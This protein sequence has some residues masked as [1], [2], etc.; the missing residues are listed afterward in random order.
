MDHAT[1]TPALRDWLAA[2]D[3]GFLAELLRLRPDAATPPPR[4]SEVLAA[5]LQLRASARRALPGLDATALAVLEAAVDLGADLE[6]VAGAAV[7]DS[8]RARLAAAG[9]PVRERPT[10]AQLRTALDAL[11]QRAL[12]IGDG[13]GRGGRFAGRAGLAGCALRVADGAWAA[14]PPGWALLPDPDRPTPERLR[15]ALA[16]IDDHQRRLLETL[17]EAGGLGTTREADPAADPAL[18]VPRLIAAGLLERVDHATVRLPAAV[19]ALLRGIPLPEG[20]VPLRPD[21][22]ATLPAGDADA[23]GAAAALE[24]IRGVR[25]LLELLGEAPAAVRRDGTVGVREHRRLVEALGP[26]LPRLV[27]VAAAAGL[28]G[29]GAPHPL[30]AEDTGGDYLAP[31]PAADAFLAAEPAARWAMLIDGLR[32]ADVDPAADRPLLSPEARRA[33]LPALRTAIG[34]L[35]LDA[36]AAVADP[37][38]AL[39]HRRPLVAVRTPPAALESALADLAA[40][41]LIAREG[42]AAAATA[43]WRAARAATGAE[44]AARL[45]PL[46][47]AP[48]GDLIAQ[49]DLT[50]LVPGPAEPALAAALARFTDVESTGVASVHRMSEESVRRGLDS[51]MTAA[52]LH[53]LLAERALGEVPQAMGFLIDD[54][55][56]RHGILRGGPAASYLR[57]A[58]AAEL[59]G[60][61][62]SPAAA[63]LGLRRLADT[64]LIAQAPLAE[65]LAA[66]RAAG[67]PAVAEDADGAVLSLAEEPRRVAEALPRTPAPQPPDAAAI[68]RAVDDVVRGDAAAAAGDGAGGTRIGMDD[69]PATGAAAQD[70]LAR[71]ARAGIEVTIGYVDRNGRALRRRVRPVTVGGGHVDALDPA[72]GRVLRFLM[73]RVTEVVQEAPPVP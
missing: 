57:C 32:G 59:A 56:R 18:P 63:G 3:R 14:L 52:E 7:L 50:I 69:D 51:G 11:R 9:A 25:D 41:G 29:V 38:G 42:P 73:H 28:L 61:M 12:V 6:P 17:V 4:S 72:E 60:I 30:P 58:D 1:E 31:A 64:V 8:V 54:V 53:A 23:R 39:L 67:R 55:A 24:L 65:V 22:P 45:A 43:A 15:A 20:R 36:G 62:A 37:A 70:L 35:L 27:A 47:P 5:R 21:P 19:R 49:E 71:A 48:T 66:L 10:L 2:R 34:D 40:L 68:A 46:L 26:E 44:L 33:D 16:G 13:P